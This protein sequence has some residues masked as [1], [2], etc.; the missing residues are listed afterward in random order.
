MRQTATH[1][2]INR[3]KIRCSGQIMKGIM[4]YNDKRDHKSEAGKI[5]STQT[6]RKNKKKLLLVKFINT[7]SQSD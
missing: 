2:R 3:L 6:E 1:E 5:W 7:V 4:K